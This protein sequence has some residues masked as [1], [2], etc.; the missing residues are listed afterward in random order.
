MGLGPRSRPAG[1][2]GGSINGIGRTYTRIEN[3]QGL[4]GAI[5]SHQ[6]K[7]KGDNLTGDE[8]EETGSWRRSEGVDRD[9]GGRSRAS[10]QRLQDG[11]WRPT[12][13][14][15]CL[16]RRSKTI[17]RVE[18][19]VQRAVQLSLRVADGMGGRYTE[20]EGGGSRKQ[21][22]IGTGF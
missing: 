5:E 11:Q 12:G 18:N 15:A 17:I 4:K 13:I 19:R 2:G 20:D 7:K 6:G 22:N 21:L 1:G 14:D 8:A 3:P 16:A 10:R 9:L